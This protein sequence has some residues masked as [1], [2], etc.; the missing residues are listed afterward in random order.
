MATVIVFG[1]LVF[2]A[3]LVILWVARPGVRALLE[4]PKHQFQDATRRY[5]RDA[6]GRQPER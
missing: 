2:A 1:S 4:R 5:D 6:G 3:A